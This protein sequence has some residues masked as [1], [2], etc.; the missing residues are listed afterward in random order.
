MHPT[1]NIVYLVGSFSDG[2]GAVDWF[3]NPFDAGVAYEKTRR[4][5][6]EI[7]DP[8]LVVWHMPILVSHGMKGEDITNYI[9]ADLPT[10]EEE[11]TRVD[12][13]ETS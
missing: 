4:E 10:L 8:T 1:K 11:A 6:E 9:D 12:Y 7:D 13:V 5:A 2:S 3:R